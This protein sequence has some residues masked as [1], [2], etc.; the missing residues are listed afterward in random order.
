MPSKPKV[1][2]ILV[3]GR[4]SPE[5][6][7]LVSGGDVIW[8]TSLDSVDIVFIFASLIQIELFELEFWMNCIPDEIQVFRLNESE[9]SL[10]NW[11]R[12]RFHRVNSDQTEGYR[13][14]KCKRALFPT[15]RLR[16]E[17][18]G[19]QADPFSK[20]YKLGLKSIRM[21]VFESIQ[22]VSELPI[23]A[24][25]AQVSEAVDP[26]LHSYRD[27]HDYN[28]KLAPLFAFPDSKN[29]LRVVNDQ[30]T[31]PWKELRKGARYRDK[32]A[33]RHKEGINRYLLPRLTTPSR[34]TVP[35]HEECEQLRRL[36]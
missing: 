8:G 29:V 5:L 3:N 22:A 14:F 17:L 30:H 20:H 23:Q 18:S 10:P 35:C 25:V 1:K 15:R 16:V 11:D 31:H 21:E 34:F 26:V 32:L 13:V 27:L 7:L 6:L 12:I 19:G 9:S 33:C 4:V 24:E 2:E 36:R 28:R